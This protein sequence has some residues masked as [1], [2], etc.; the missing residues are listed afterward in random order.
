MLI[1]G[2]NDIIQPPEQTALF[3]MQYCQHN[4]ELNNKVLLLL[5]ALCQLSLYTMADKTAIR[6]TQSV[7]TFMRLNHFHG[8][9][10][11]F[12]QSCTFMQQ[13]VSSVLSL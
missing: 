9:S 7:M 10:Y 6:K 4:A 8:V 12:T 2:D 5:E 11:L 13:E 1:K 3:S